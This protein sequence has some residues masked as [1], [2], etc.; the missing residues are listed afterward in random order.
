MI[1]GMYRSATG[2]MTSTHRMNTIANNLANSST[3]GFKRDLAATMER[4][5]AAAERGL[6]PTASNAMLE[7]IGGG[8]LLMPTRFDNSTGGMEKTPN[9]LDLAIDGNGFFAVRQNGQTR[10]TRNG[11]FQMNQEGKLVTVD[12][13]PVLDVELKPIQLDPRIVPSV[14]TTGAI[15]QGGSVVARLAVKQ[16]DDTNSLH[17]EGMTL[18]SHPA[19]AGLMQLGNGKAPGR[20]LSNSLEQANVDPT[21]ELTQLMA[22]QRELEANAN[23]IKTQ[24][25]MLGR[26]VTEVGKIS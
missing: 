20:V 6:G 14:D 8:T 5:T 21:L 12:G 4:R 15:V 24:D 13:N 23:M 2:V 16:V 10:L 1:Y 18:F 17:K 22:A 9:P 3:V 26:L 19:V 11:Q 25:A 7:R